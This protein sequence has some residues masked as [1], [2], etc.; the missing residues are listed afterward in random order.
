MRY[1]LLFVGLL[2]QL[3]GFL[4][5]CK[6]FFPTKVLLTEN[7]E[8]QWLTAFPDGYSAPDAKFER[9]IFM[10]VDAMRA[11]FIFSDKSNMTFAHKL[12]NDGYGVGF[13][14]F[15]NPP[16]VTLPRLKGITTGSTPNFIDA[17]LNIAEDDTSSSLGSQDSWIKQMFM[18]GWKINMFGDDT[19]LKLFPDYFAKTDGTASFYVSDYTIVDNN[20][21]RHLDYELSTEGKNQWDCM[22]LHYL[23]LD[24]IGH[25]G[26]AD[27][28]NMPGKQK[29]MDEIIERI[30]NES[31]KNHPDTLFVILG[32]HGMNDVGNHGGSSIAE[33][34]S[35]LMLISDKF[36]NYNLNDG[37]KAPIKWDEEYRYF[38]RVDQIDLVPTLSTLIGLKIPMNNLGSFI[39][40]FLSMYSTEREQKNVLLKNAIQ[41][42]VLIDKSLGKKTNLE[43]TSI[44]GLT[45]Y[46]A[47][48]KDEL[49]RSSSN[50]NY[51]DLHQG[52]AIYIFTTL[53]SFIAFARNFKGNFK[54]AFFDVVFFFT[55]SANFIASSFVEEEHHLWWF[56]TTLFLAYLII[57]SIKK[58]N[59][60]F[61]GV[62]LMM[63]SLRLLK[64]WNNSGQ[65]NNLKSNIKIGTYLSELADDFGPNV[66]AIILF[67]S[68]IPLVVTIDM[69]EG[70]IYQK[71]LQGL[72]SMLIF[73]ALTSKLL[74]YLT[75]TFDLAKENNFPSW[76]DTF[77]KYLHS[78]TNLTDFNKINNLLFGIL[79]KLWLGVFVINMIKPVIVKRIKGIS[80]T[81][82]SY[83]LNTLSIFAFI[84]I[85]Q[86]NYLN[87]PIFAL[88]YV[89]MFG[90]K[91]FAP[92][93]INNNY[94]NLFT[95]MMQNLTFFQ[96]GSTN[97]ISTVDLTNSFNGL[98]SYNVFMCGMLTYLCNWAGPLFWSVA[99]LYL[100]IPKLA[101]KSNK[102]K[103]DYL[104]NRLIFNFV[105]YGVSGSM[106]LICCYYL[107]FHLFIWTV[108]SPKILYFLSW[109][110]CNLF[111][112]TLF[113]CLILLFYI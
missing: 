94:I 87:V 16:T 12:L 34:S 68:F 104:F 8:S 23:G 45:I 53:I 73:I 75:S 64:A 78:T 9:V 14:A 5:F 36:L 111:F 46:I 30:F 63:I 83:I 52:L 38:K 91:S 112:D 1:P 58:K 17:V 92:K 108:F 79:Q 50:Y 25:K 43:D 2:V 18:S 54:I 47:E 86:T 60:K 97:S 28:V 77:I 39:P 22:I 29:E 84:L 100:T 31:I 56:F 27:S 81:R 96:F 6:G 13:T 106:L 66:Y 24:H 26:G 72:C 69:H 95:I 109:L 42:K 4:L 70:T 44:D 61:F 59:F 90:F 113:S 40:S 48:A 3:L 93:S 35:G 89:I 11:D 65:K 71:C 85:S 21:T 19:W 32:D 51:T 76:C 55:Y 88:L 20:V 74:S 57:S 62:L 98:S 82:D 49:S 102:S 15:S 67:I 99:Y 103:W 101:E 41:L 107:R 7:E 105:F 110:L 37:V 10:V 80:E 33:T